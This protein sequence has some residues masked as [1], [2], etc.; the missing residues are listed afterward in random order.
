MEKLPTI[1]AHFSLCYEAELIHSKT[2]KIIESDL[3]N[4]EHLFLQIK[5]HYIDGLNSL[6]N[7]D[8][9]WESSISPVGQK[10]KNEERGYNYILQVFE[11]ESHG[12]AICI[13]DSNQCECETLKE[14]F[15]FSNIGFTHLKVYIER[16]DIDMITKNGKNF[17]QSSPAM[18]E[19]IKR[20]EKIQS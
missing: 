1:E 6:L 12:A 15:D 10:R 9:S 18:L 19:I 16:E 20:C 2:F 13:C 14:F 11:K 17:I 4:H 8:L 3:K 7:R 5:D